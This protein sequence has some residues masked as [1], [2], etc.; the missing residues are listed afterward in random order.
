MRFVALLLSAAALLFVTA[1]RLSAQ[2]WSPTAATGAFSTGSN[3]TGGLVPTSGTGTNLVFAATT[4]PLVNLSSSINVNTI[5]FNGTYPLYKLSASGG[6]SLGIGNGA[7]TGATTLSVAA[8]SPNNFVDFS[9]GLPISLLV[10]QT[11]STAGNLSVYG[12]ISGA[13]SLTKTGAGYLALGGSSTFSGGVTVSTGKLNLSSNTGAGTGT[14]TLANGTSLVNFFSSI[15]AAN[16]ITITGSGSTVNFGD[17][18]NGSLELKLTGPITLPSAT[19]T[20]T[21]NALNPWPV[22][23]QG[24]IIQPGGFTSTLAITGG[25]FAIFSGTNNYAGGTTVSGGSGLTFM[26]SASLPALGNLT[27]TGKSYVG[28]GYSGGLASV[29]S[30]SRITSPSSSSLFSGSLGFDTAPTAGSPTTFSDTLALSGFNT[31]SNFGGIGSFSRAIVSGA[32]T[33]AS[34]Q[35]YKFGGGNGTLFVTSNL[36]ANGGSGLSV[37][38][39]TAVTGEDDHLNVFLQGT[40]TFTGGVKVTASSLIFDSPGALPAGVAFVLGDDS[41]VG[42]TENATNVSNFASFVTKV[43]TVSGSSLFFDAT[44]GIDSRDYVANLKSP[45]SVTTPTARTVADTIDLSSLS[46]MFLGTATRAILTG[47][48]KPPNSGDASGDGILY[49]SG[50]Y[51]GYLTITSPLTVANGITSVSVGNNENEP[52][53]VTYKGYVELTGAS[54]Y[55]GGTTLKSGYLLLGNNSALGTGTLTATL[56]PYGPTPDIGPPSLAASVNGIA[57]ANNI[58]LS[59]PLRVGVTANSITTDFA[60]PLQSFTANSLTLAGIISGSSSLDYLGTGTLTLTGANTYTGGTSVSGGKLFVNNASGSGTGTGTVTVGSGGVLGGAG[61]ISGALVLNS[62]ATLAPG[63]SPGTLTVG[64]TTMASAAIFAFDINNAVGI[65]GTNWDLLSISGALNFTAT[66]AAPLT[67]NLTSLTTANTAGLL[68]N[69]NAAT[70]FSWQFVSTTGGITGFSA[71]AFQYNTS[72]FQNSLAGGSFG[73]SQSVDGKNLFLNFSPVP[74]PSTWALLVT[75]LG[76]LAL[77][78]RRRRRG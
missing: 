9:F 54:N 44:I 36:L 31:N 26:T 46:R 3:W 58:V 50:I 40:N 16:P 30:A 21:F 74:E 55:T 12:D 11:W 73:V 53:D 62:G 22:Q 77:T 20:T 33:V 57:L 4:S 70:A 38:S 15:T 69:F 24:D 13:F 34:G 6:A 76:A 41:Y 18:T 71:G 49:V 65:A 52:G 25:K 37:I 56:S 19:T 42:Y 67:L 59:T 23:F 48:I 63:N 2:T 61:F 28:F 35:E 14:I 29:I 45:G 66:P 39:S 27:L 75:G 72:Q 32:I 5:T 8:G 47:T 51:G 60:F 78:T 7:T 10:N 43:A 64:P 68:T 17:T 1:S